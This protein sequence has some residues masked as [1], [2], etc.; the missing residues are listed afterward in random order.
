M[1][2]VHTDTDI[3]TGL[4]HCTVMSDILNYK[5]DRLED[6]IRWYSS[7]ARKNKTKYH[8]FQTLVIVAAAMVPVINTQG[9]IGE[10]PHDIQVLLMS[11]FAAAIAAIFAG[12]TEVGK[13]QETWITY[14]TTTEL[15]KREKFFYVSRSG[16]YADLDD[17]QR[18]RLLVE[19]VE[20]FIA[21]ETSKYFALHQ[22]KKTKSGTE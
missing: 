16:E 5:E 22:P 19:R 14:R 11:S 13:Y 17:I 20:S 9:C 6:Q 18:D 21:T 10:N 15:L 12:L 4:Q 8:M 7:Q 2:I 1:V 3:S